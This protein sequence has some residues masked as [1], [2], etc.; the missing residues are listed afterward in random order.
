MFCYFVHCE[1]DA[2]VTDFHI[3]TGHD[4]VIVIFIQ[5]VFFL[6]LE[7]PQSTRLNWRCGEEEDEEEENEREK[8]I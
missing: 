6:S 7:H 3:A 2:V 5:S 8:E 4:A 1:L